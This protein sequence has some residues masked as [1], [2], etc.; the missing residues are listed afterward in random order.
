[1]NRN[2]QV[3]RAMEE[4]FPGWTRE[5]RPQLGKKEFNAFRDGV[6]KIFEQ[7]NY[8]PS[9]E[10]NN[11]TMNDLFLL[12]PDSKT[13][14]AWL[15][16]TRTWTDSIECGQLSQ[17]D[18]IQDRRCTT[19]FHAGAMFHD[20]VNKPHLFN[21]TRMSTGSFRYFD[22]KEVTKIVLNFEPE[23]YADLKRQIGARIVFHASKHVAS[24]FQRDFFVTR[25]YRYDFSIDR[26]DLMVLDRPYLGCWDYEENNLHKFKTEINPRVPLYSETCYQNCIIRSIKHMSDCWPPTM[27]Y[28]RNDSLDPD[29]SL[30]PCLWF[31]EPQY[32]SIYNQMLRTERLK[33]EKKNQ[34]LGA[35]ETN[36]PIISNY[37]STKDMKTY[38]KVRRFC[39]SKCSLPCKLTQYSVT[40]T[41]ST[42]PSDVEVI[43]DK[44]TMQRKLRH[45]CA[46]ITIK[47]L[48][49]H[50]KV[51]EFI[52]KYNI[53]DT[54]GNLGGLLAVWLGL[55]M[56][57]VYHAIQKL[58]EF[59]NQ[60]SL[61]N[62]Q[63][64]T[65]V[66]KVNSGVKQ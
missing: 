31:R 11:N 16:C 22:A 43:F 14:V 17:I 4:R 12:K 21:S 29:L 10:L 23:D 13:F 52:P 36:A 40:V 7:L 39:W 35:K 60:R 45:C 55:S 5:Q 28:F 8:S 32:I 42:W 61:N 30:K 66:Y 9:D 62:I 18:S 47:Y 49:Y 46:L 50:H 53:V 27:P 63:V 51:H 37:N 38:T 19:I 54:A 59:C 26:E 64:Q 44:T 56:V 15:D 41:R 1:M 20:L 25:G 3:G 65:N 24:T 57:S 33:K 58:V 48:Y 34:K 6:A 2:R